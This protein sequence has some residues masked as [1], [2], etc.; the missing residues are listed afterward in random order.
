MAPPTSGASGSGLDVSVNAVHKVNVLLTL[1]TRA[2]A[3]DRPA[4]A[5]VP[6]ARRREIKT[7][8]IVEVALRVLVDHGIDALTLQRVAR[9]IGLTTTALYRYFPS[10]DA[11]VAALQRQAVAEIH[12][13]VAALVASIEPALQRRSPVVAAL[14]RV[15][16][17][18]RL[19]LELPRSHPETYHLVAVLLGDPR[20]LIADEHAVATVPLLGALL[21]DVGRLLDAVTTLRGFEPG[22]PRDRGLMLWSLLQ[23]L[24]QLDKLARLAPAAPDR[25]VL[26]QAA[27]AALLRGFGATAGALDRAGDAI[28]GTFTKR[29]RK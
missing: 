8:V 17:V 22:P 6:H 14:A 3:T 18:A 27:V 21:D 10:K 7:D 20:R 16:A 9:E 24:N 23:G 11:L 4:A 26:G 5:F 2:R 25:I 15:L 28:D 19:Y 13:E 1:S 12:R 29:R